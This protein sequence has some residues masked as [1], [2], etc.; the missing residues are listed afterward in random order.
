MLLR[1]LLS[2]KRPAFI[3]IF[4]WIELDSMIQEHTLSNGIRC[5]P[6]N[7]LSQSCNITE[8]ALV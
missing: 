2:E 5:L 3:G 1:D 7:L 4:D 8:L 6:I